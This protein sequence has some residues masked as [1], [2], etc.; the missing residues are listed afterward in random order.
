MPSPSSDRAKAQGAIAESTDSV[1]DETATST[2]AIPAR[3]EGGLRRA[4]AS[5]AA[6]TT[7][8]D[9]AEAAYIAARDAWTAAMRSSSTGR[10]ADLAALALAQEAYEAAAAERERWARHQTVAIPIDTTAARRDLDIVVGQEA[11]WHRL[12]ERDPE[13]GGLM[14]K[15]KRLFGG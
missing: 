4:T 1:P 9:E 8:A 10:A 2:H 11:E 7:S 15:V 3:G 14:A 13:R 6:A 5:R 12:K